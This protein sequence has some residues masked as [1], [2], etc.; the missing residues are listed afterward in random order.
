MF[1]SV[2]VI[3]SSLLLFYC[4]TQNGI[5]VIGAVIFIF[6]F[7]VFIA[8]NIKFA[9]EN[10]VPDVFKESSEDEAVNKKRDL[11]IDFIKFFISSVAMVVGS[12]LLI[13][14][15]DELALHLGVTHR[16]ISTTIIAIAT[17]FPEMVTAITAFSKKQST[18]SV[19][20][21]IGANI[22]DLTLILPV[23]TLLS[24]G[25]LP[26]SK[27][28]VSIDI[29]ILVAVTLLAVVPSLIKGKFMR[30]Q[31]AVLL[32]I[33]GAYFLITCGFITV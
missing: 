17:S 32:S 4:G 26:F 1:E 5:G 30:W 28:V 18:I 7:G 19:G 3:I 15:G 21:I 14:N 25:Y 8:Q 6:L 13:D 2:L 10:T 11:T 9:Y 33:Y 16:V 24:G 31:G 23:A 27:E 29:L 12:R 22:I 20:N